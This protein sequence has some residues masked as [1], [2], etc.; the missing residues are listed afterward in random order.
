MTLLTLAH[1]RQP[2]EW[3]PVAGP[4]TSSWLSSSILWKQQQ[5]HCQLINALDAN[6]TWAGYIVGL[7][8]LQLRMHE[9]RALISTLH[10]ICRCAVEK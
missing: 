6:I 5:T 2:I 9:R 8:K 10:L 7:R 3:L 4:P 1:A